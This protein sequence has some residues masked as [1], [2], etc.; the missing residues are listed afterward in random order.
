MPDCKYCQVDEV[1]VNADCPMCADFC[2]VVDVP[3]V[4][5]FEEREVTMDKIKNYLPD[6]EILAQLAEEA[7]ELAQAAL[8][9]RRVIDGTNPTPKTREDAFGSL[10]EEYSDVVSC[11]RELN[12]LPAEIIIAGKKERWINRLKEKNNEQS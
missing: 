3:G 6:E 9:L 1:C 2:P 5:R 11:C 12:I 10:I 8:K 7:A 4:C